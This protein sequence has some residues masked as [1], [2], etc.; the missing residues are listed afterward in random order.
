MF[1]Q[2]NIYRKTCSICFILVLGGP[3][4]QNPPAQQP[5]PTIPFA[6]VHQNVLGPRAPLAPWPSAAVSSGVPTASASVS[7]IRGVQPY[8]SGVAPM[9]VPAPPR[10]Q[11]MFPRPPQPISPSSGNMS[12]STNVVNRMKPE[13][14]KPREPSPLDL[15][16]QEALTAHKESQ[17][18]P[19]V[20]I[21]IQPEK[22]DAMLLDIGDSVTPSQPTPS[23]P[24][25]P[26]ATP[27][28]NG[29]KAH[30]TTL[31]QMSLSMDKIQPG[32]YSVPI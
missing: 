9:M 22:K 30:D 3:T 17:N 32:K 25:P 6:P 29:P 1:D 19:K 5:N 4:S 27:T 18:K 24:P 2:K 12:W 10:P 15:L 13:E 28:S 11:V 14:P 21:N 8:S 7:T 26:A 20:E 23:I 16:G 31:D